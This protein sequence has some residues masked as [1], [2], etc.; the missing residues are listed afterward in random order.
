MTGGAWWGWERGMYGR[1]VC[2]WHGGGMCG[3]GHAWQRGVH[4]RGR[5]ASQGVWMACMPPS[6]R[7]YEIRS[8]SDGTHPNGMLSCF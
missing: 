4:G 8:M 7:Y 2:A 6:G 5:H 1:R 3:E